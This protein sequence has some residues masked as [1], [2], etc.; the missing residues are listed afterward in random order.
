MN[1][2]IVV[3][4]A[5]HWTSKNDDKVYNTLDYIIT[6]KESLVESEKFKGYQIVTSWLKKSLVKEIEPLSVYKATFDTHMEGLKSTLVLKKLEHK[7]G[8]VIDLS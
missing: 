3:I 6:S 5:R 4:N 1:L 2:E 8:T 7:N